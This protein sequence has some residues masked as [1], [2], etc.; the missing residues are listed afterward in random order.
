MDRVIQLFE[1]IAQE[2]KASNDRVVIGIGKIN[3]GNIL[4]RE[5]LKQTQ[6]LIL[7]LKAETTQIITAMNARMTFDRYL[8]SILIIA[9]IVLAGAEKAFQFLP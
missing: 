1:N 7:A 6:N 5:D 3:D 2:N 4:H 9:I 8:I